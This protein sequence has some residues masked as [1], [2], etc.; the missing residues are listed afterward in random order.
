LPE[1][2]STLEKLINI[3]E[4]IFIS[5]DTQNIILEEIKPLVWN[6]EKYEGEN[7][8]EFIFSLYM[9]VILIQN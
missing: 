8:F 5:D 2:A 1:Q 7:S 3:L 6:Q 4:K 9:I